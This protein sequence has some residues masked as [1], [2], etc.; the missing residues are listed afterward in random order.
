MSTDPFAEIDFGGDRQ[1]DG[2]QPLPA[3]QRIRQTDPIRQL[4]YD[5]RGLAPLDAS[6]WA[7][8]AL[9]YKQGLLMQHF[10]DSYEKCVPL[11]IYAPTY[12]RLSYEQLRTYFTWRTSAR[13]GQYASVSVSYVLL[14]AY[15]IINNIGIQNIQHGPEMLLKLW[16]A[17][18]EDAPFLDELFPVWILDFHIYYCLQSNLEAFVKQHSL[19]DYYSNHRLFDLHPTHSLNLWGSISSYKYAES[20]FYTAGNQETMQTAFYFVL[21]ALRQHYKSIGKPF[22]RLLF[23]PLQ[24][25]EWVPFFDAPIHRS[26]MQQN[27][28]ITVFQ[29]QK[30]VCS[31]GKWQYMPLIRHSHAHAVA[32]CLIKITEGLLRKQLGFK[33]QF[34]SHSPKRSFELAQPFIL[35]PNGITLHDFC[36][37]A[38]QD[39]LRHMSRVVVNVNSKNLD[40]IRQQSLA[41]QESLIVEETE[42]VHM[43]IATTNEPAQTSHSTD[44]PWQSLHAALTPIEAEALRL[45][46]TT[47]CQPDA[48]WQLANAHATMP[49]VLIDGINE[50]AVDTVQDNII[51]DDMAVYEDYVDFVKF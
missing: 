48:L 51:G 8:A 18:R 17:Y 6:L 15:E 31:G 42:P 13:A 12:Q 50:K 43:K 37:T 47:P 46:I 26:T 5:M 9:F 40:R 4:F 28:N 29:T 11:N 44:N 25:A 1:Q 49:Q 19:Q 32:A 35:L 22:Y 39:A 16:Q 10:E 7:S 34:N 24:L 30:Y 3:A 2:A 20:S 38:V 33:G 23:S 45:I 21:T 36:Q 27:E 41:T 14:Y